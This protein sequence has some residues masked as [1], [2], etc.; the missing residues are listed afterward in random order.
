MMHW[1]KLYHEILTDSKV[2]VLS[3]TLWRRMVELFLLAGIERRGGVL[4]PL[5]QMGWILHINHDQLQ[6]ELQCL[7]EIGIVHFDP[8]IER[9]VVT[10]F[11][12]RQRAS[13]TAERV[14]RYRNVKKLA[15]ENA[16][17]EG[18]NVTKD[19]TNHVTN[20]YIN[21]YQDIKN[22]DINKVVVVVKDDAANSQVSPEVQQAFQA[23]HKE[24]G[25]MTPLISEKVIAAVDDYGVDWVTAAI[26]EAAISNARNWR[27][28][29]GILKNWKVN[30]FRAPKKQHNH[31]RP[32]KR[33]Q[34]HEKNAEVV[35]KILGGQ[36]NGNS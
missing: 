32:S 33:Q 9:W 5:Q 8:E 35:R 16:K 34:V 6:H 27:Y 12:E 23:Y 20:R 2:G 28:V 19:V 1:I 31:S 24:I 30:G 22:T 10:N 14:R 11:A 26:S 15:M 4:P 21:R 7:S 17:T 29:E 3:D 13:S 18:E 25:P 36:N